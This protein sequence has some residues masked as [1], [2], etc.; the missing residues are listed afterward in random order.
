MKSKYIGYTI[1]FGLTAYTLSHLAVNL[2]MR[3][4]LL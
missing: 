3:G 4:G 1:A 2:L